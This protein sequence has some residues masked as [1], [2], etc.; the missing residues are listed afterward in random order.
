MKD[1]S[2]NNT[3]AVITRQSIF[4]DAP[5]ETHYFRDLAEAKRFLG[6]C[7]KYRT[8]EQALLVKVE[9]WHEQVDDCTHYKE[10]VS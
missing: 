1:M 7:I 9:E 10:A 4:V 3:W 6:K 8:A 2:N 5:S